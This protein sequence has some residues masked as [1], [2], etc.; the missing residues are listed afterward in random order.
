[1]ASQ[2]EIIRGNITHNQQLDAERQAAAS[3]FGAPEQPEIANGIPS[4]SNDAALAA[5]LKETRDKSAEYA[6]LRTEEAK[7]QWETQVADNFR[8]DQSRKE[9]AAENAAAAKLNQEAEDRKLGDSLALQMQALTSTFPPD[10]TPWTLPKDKLEALANLR[11]KVQN[12]AAATGAPGLADGVL[13]SGGPL[14]PAN[15]LGINKP[16][17]VSPQDAGTVTENGDGTYTVKLQTGEIFKGNAIDVMQAQAA[18]QVN[19]KLWA[20]QKVAQAQQSQPAVE[21]IQQPTEQDYSGS[22]SQDLAARQA[23]AIAQQFGFSDKNEM[24]QWGETVSQKIA[25]I[26][27]YEN[28]K[29]A[30]RFCADCPDFPSTPE[31]VNAL[32]SIVENNGWQWNGESLQAAH[33]LAVRNHI[34]EPLTAEQIQAANGIM[35][36]NKRPTPPP[37]LSGNNPE[38]TGGGA[39]TYEQLINMPSSESRKLAIAAELQGRGSNY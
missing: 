5:H 6:R 11:Q 37:I 36:Q 34:Y 16:Q 38:I 18:A 2:A 13:E 3:N 27:E 10:W 1:M 30:T 35:P 33:A 21:A 15:V 20:R 31:A 24:Q 39:Y 9:I 19:T 23:D 4:T 29:L 17:K 22:L 32:T 7:E 25:T 26:Q 8:R 28:E 12:L 14:A